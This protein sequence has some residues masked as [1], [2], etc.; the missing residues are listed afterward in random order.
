MLIFRLEDSVCYDRERVCDGMHR[1]VYT[2]NTYYVGS[3]REC[4]DILCGGYDPLHHPTPQSDPKLKHVWY[5][6][7]NSHKFFFGFTS[8]NQ[9]LRWFCADKDGY[10]KVAELNVF[11]VAV[12]EIEDK[13]VIE[14]TKQCIFEAEH[15]KIHQIY[16]LQEFYNLFGEDYVNSSF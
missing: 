16:T 6:M 11:R 5:E 10:Y 7:P 1:G 3:G 14:G 4:I 2:T 13:F 12:Y 8:T 15:A 9:L